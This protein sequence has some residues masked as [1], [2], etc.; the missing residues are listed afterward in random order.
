[1]S[2]FDNGKTNYD[3]LHIRKQIETICADPTLSTEERAKQIYPLLPVT[4]K[5]IMNLYSGPD[6]TDEWNI[7]NTE[8]GKECYNFMDKTPSIVPG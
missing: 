7:K 6:Y 5:D 4:D 3:Y 2:T 8:K 1:M